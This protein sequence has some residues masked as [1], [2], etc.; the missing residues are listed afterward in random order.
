MALFSRKK[1]LP[2]TMQ[3]LELRAYDG[4]PSSLALVERPIPR[5]RHGEVL[6][7]I[8]ATPINPSDLSFLLGL[9]VRKDLP[10]VPGFEASGQVVASGGGI[11]ARV[12]TGRRVACAAPRDGDG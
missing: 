8:A 3:A 9:Y 10:V 6:V 1:D 4:A 2:P 11:G 7:R 5:P 12:L